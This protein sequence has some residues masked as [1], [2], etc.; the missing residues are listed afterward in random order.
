[1][2]S[3][4]QIGELQKDCLLL[5]V[6][7]WIAGGVYP[8]LDP[9]IWDAYMHS[10]E[11]DRTVQIRYPSIAHLFEGKSFNDYIFHNKVGE[12]VLPFLKNGKLKAFGDLVLDRSWPSIEDYDDTWE[13]EHNN[14][15]KSIIEKQNE[16]IN[17]DFWKEAEIKF[18]ENEARSEDKHYVNIK[19]K[20]EELL[21]CFPDQ[22]YETH[23]EISSKNGKKKG[24]KAREFFIEEFKKMKIKHPKKDDEKI[25]NLILKEHSDFFKKEKLKTSSIG[26]TSENWIKQRIQP[27]EWYQKLKLDSK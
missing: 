12:D 21:K 24:E 11:M 3:I 26:R 13:Y 7:Q 22:G 25:Q 27:S 18:Y 2:R 8:T 6:I 4:I 14:R 5:E 16:L 9:N 20:T 19:V 1:M 23:Q 17:V 10:G 15:G